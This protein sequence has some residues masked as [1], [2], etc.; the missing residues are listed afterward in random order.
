MHIG[1]L[2]PEYPHPSLSRSGGLGTSIKNL[3][4]ALVTAGHQAT[5]FV[6]NQA[7]GNCFEHEGVKV[8]VIKQKSYPV[9]SWYRQRKYWQRVIQKEVEVHK[10]DLLEA[11]DWTGLSA[12]MQFKVPLI[13]RLN[14]SDGYFCHLENRKQKK[15]HRFLE[16]RALIKA[17]TIVSVSQFTASIT[18]QVFQ[19]PNKISHIIPNGISVDQFKP[20]ITTIHKNQI[21]YFGTVV[22]KKGVL[23]LAYMFNLLIKKEPNAELLFLG[24]DNRD[25]F[26]NTS[27]VGLIKN[28]LSTEAIK[29]VKF[30]SEVTYEEVKHYIAEAQVITLPS[31]AEAFPM[32]WLESLAMEKALVSSDVGWAKELMV[33]G[34][35][36]FTVNPKEHANYADY[37][38]K[39]ISNPDLCEKMG[40]TGRA[41]VSKQFSNTVVTARNIDFY[42]SIIKT[43]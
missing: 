1:F 25:V 16:K 24:K 23:E 14:G 6:V 38:M 39:L 11:P 7:D 33:H 21:L 28:I 5:V 20:L 31:F 19:L 18:E 15:K 4:S 17:H 2:T 27:T 37:I 35:T 8:I 26:T 29:R 36:G 32:T 3:A 12:F 9:L 43:N 22:R 13:I 30:I 10:I 42:R 34:E 41:H 40:K